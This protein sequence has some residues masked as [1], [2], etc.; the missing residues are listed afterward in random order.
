MI[1]YGFAL[2][3]AG[4][5]ALEAAAHPDLEAQIETL[6]AELEMRPRDAE[7]LLRRGDLHRRHEDH[8]SARRDFAA[9]READ[10]GH[11][12]LDLYAG[13]LDLEAGDAQS[14]VKLLGRYLESKPDHALAWR[15]HGEALCTLGQFEDA[16]NSFSGAIEHSPAP[17]PDLFRLQALSWLA[18]G[19]PGHLPASEVVDAGLAHFGT[20]VT[21]LGLGVDLA[22]A[23]GLA[24]RARALFDTAPDG[25]LK[26]PDWTVRG[27]LLE[28]LHATGACESRA[29]ARLE[30]V[31]ADFRAEWSDSRDGS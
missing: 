1:R 5:L 31:I 22:L 4:F 20:E 6:T 21:L 28:C 15:L 19:E 29:R 13:R 12:W 16:A 10:P 18:L 11:P 9:A 2:L 23:D 27:E 7:L 3:F 25:L 24:D 8:D 30:Q 14:A 26:L 17:S